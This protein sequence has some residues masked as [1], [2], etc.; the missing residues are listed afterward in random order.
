ME[1]YIGTLEA[2]NR[3]LFLKINASPAEP[4]WLVNGVTL[5]ATDL[6][7][8]IPLLLLT[9]WFWGEEARRNLALKACLVAALGVGLNQL[10]RF[11]WPHPRPFMLGLGQTYLS[12]A[13]DSSFPSDHMTLFV[14]IAL[15]LLIG[16]STRLAVLTL[17]AGLCNGWARIFLGIHFPLDMVGAVGV[18]GIA[19]AIVSPIW[20]KRGDATMRLAERI[21]R[22]ILALPIAS[23]WIRR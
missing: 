10:I 18:A 1:Q 5:I 21:Y 9:M 22:K 7:Y 2:L 23:G 15:S 4:A 11:A 3:A 19:Y 20:R 14:A 12:H 13:P 17:L 6:I 16:V 8:M